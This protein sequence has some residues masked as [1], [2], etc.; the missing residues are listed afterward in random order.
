MQGLF[1]QL[2]AFEFL[3]EGSKFFFSVV[4]YEVATMQKDDQIRQNLWRK[5]EKFLEFEFFKRNLHIH[6]G[7][8]GSSFLQY[9]KVLTHELQI[10][11]QEAAYV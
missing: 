10:N 11:L 3:T 6:P 4:E 8:I 7:W 2:A 1:K 5:T 9:T